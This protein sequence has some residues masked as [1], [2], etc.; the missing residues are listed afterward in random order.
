MINLLSIPDK[1]KDYQSY[2]VFVLCILWTAVVG[3]TVSLGFYFLPELWQRWFTFLAISLF[4]AVFNLSIIRFGY[5]RLASWTLTIMLWLLITIPCYSAGGIMAPGILSQ[6]SVI[7]TAGFLLGWRGGLAIG[8]LTVGADFSLA[9]MEMTGLL[10][11]PSVIHTPITRWVGA[12]IPFGTILALQ[13]YATNHLRSSLV[14]V[15][16]E[17]AKRE[18]AEKVMTQTVLN[19]KERVKELRTLYEVGKILQNY[20]ASINDLVYQIAEIVPQGW[21]YTEIAGARV[22]FGNIE[23]CTSNYKPS[24]YCQRAELKTK[25]ETEVYIEVVY[26]QKAAEA[27]EGPFLKEERHL[28]NM[29]CEIMRMNLESREH[30]TELKDYKYALDLGSIVGIAGV[31]GILK[32]VNDNYCKISKYNRSELI[33]KHHSISTA[34][35]HASDYFDALSIALQDG[36]PVRGDFC[37]MAKDGTMYWVDTTIVPFLDVNGN[38]YQYLSL[39]NDITE[40]K[41]AEEKIKQNEQLLKKMTSQVPGNSYIF[42]IEESGRTVLLF[43]NRGTDKFNHNYNLDELLAN[44]DILRDILHEDDKGKF[45]EMMRK[46]YL[47]H[48]SISFQYRIVVNDRIRWRWMQAS[49][50][51]DKSG[52]M[53]WYGVTSDITPLVDY[54]ISIEQIIYDITH[55][56]RRPVTTLHGLS[57]LI[58]EAKLSDSEI[59]EISA[60]FYE[61]AIEMDKFTRELNE[62]YQEKRKNTDLSIDISSIVDKRGSLF[63]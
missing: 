20:E 17:V 53:L 19:L 4:I 54:I 7:L 6:V 10:P 41:L 38:V 42:E 44:P 28:I 21:Q 36:K 25:Y 14:A 33:G 48:S 5:I 51:I 62:A 49:P 27:D 52:K 16:R 8:L 35:F 55:V 29:L 1:E 40:R 43:T 58:M 50:E 18:E 59:R 11:A 60:K 23:H 34:H 56:I 46:A 57:K 39:N 31:D 63:A 15:Q 3:G 9:Y 24:E 26:L 22:C 12:I 61:I 13:Y 2:M 45:N 47:T 30:S 37:N 32:V